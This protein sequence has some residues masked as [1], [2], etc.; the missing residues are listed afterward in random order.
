MEL[1]QEEQSKLKLL[2]EEE[3]VVSLPQQEQYVM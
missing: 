2:H 3:R 1:P